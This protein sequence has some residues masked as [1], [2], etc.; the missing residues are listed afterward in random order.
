MRAVPAD[1]HLCE[2]IDWDTV[3][4]TSPDDVRGA[5]CCNVIAGEGIFATLCVAARV[6]ASEVLALC[7]RH[8]GWLARLQL[9]MLAELA[10]RCNVRT[11]WLLQL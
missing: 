11:S 6:D 2:A 7:V 3:P 8:V 4:S 1:V 9:G 5:Y 10:A